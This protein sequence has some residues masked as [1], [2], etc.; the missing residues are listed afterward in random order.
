[1][2]R[3]TAGE[4]QRTAKPAAYRL[5]PARVVVL[6]IKNP[7]NCE[8]GCA[9]SAKSLR[10]VIKSIAMN[11]VG[12]VVAILIGGLAGCRR[13]LPSFGTVPPFGQ[14]DLAGQPWIADFI[15][16][17]CDGPCPVLSANMARLQTRLPAPF[18]LVSFTIDPEHD[19]PRVL[20]E[21]GQRFGADPARWRF[22]R[23]DEITLAN[24]L[25]KGFK[26]ALVSGD[27]NIVHSTKF[28]LVD[29]RGE[30]R[31]YYDGNDEEAFKRLE[32]DAARL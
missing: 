7:G 14:P 27:G 11:R 9:P 1:M 31:G 21:Y 25:T 20:A 28:V 24:L 13:N 23:L 26:L 12:L 19:T 30:I 6:T 2:E 22:V 3:F 29:G 5:W 18:Q 10:E 4:A 8:L 32:A 16:T 17:T 15:Y